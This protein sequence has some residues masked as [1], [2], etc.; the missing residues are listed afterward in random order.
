[1]RF[2]KLVFVGEKMLV[3]E[4]YN[5]AVRVPLTA[6]PNRESRGTCPPCRSRA[7]PLSPTGETS[8][9]SA[10]TP[11]GSAVKRKR[12]LKGCGGKQEFSPT[13]RILSYK[14]SPSKT[15][16]WTVLDVSST[17]KKEFPTTTCIILSAVK[18]EAD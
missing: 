11:C 8:A 3:R 4:N 15:V 9:L 6:I 2:D 5:L 13:C 12:A 7:E 1:M 10:A 17:Y 18:P 16:H 14:R